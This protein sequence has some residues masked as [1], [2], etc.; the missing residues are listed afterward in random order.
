[1]ISVEFPS[2]KRK[3][4]TSRVPRSIGCYICGRQYMLHSF[5]IHEEQCRKLFIDRELLKPLKER[6]KIPDNPFNK[7]LIS[8]NKNSVEEMNDIAYTAYT[9]NLSSCKYCDRKFNQDKLKIH[10]KSCTAV[11]PA[12]RVDESVNRRT[13]MSDMKQMEYTLDRIEKD[14]I[15]FS[16]LAAYSTLVPAELQQCPHCNRSFNER[17]Y[18]KH[19]KIC[20]KVF[21]DK[22]KAFDSRKKRIEGTELASFYNDKRKRIGSSKIASKT[23][24]YFENNNKVE[25]SSK[26]RQQSQQFRQAMKA[27]RIVKIAQNRSKE[28]GIP[29]A[30]LLPQSL[31]NNEMDYN[32]YIT[33]PTCGRRFNEISGQRHITHCQSIRNKPSVLL[34]RSGH[35]ATTFRDELTRQKMR[36]NSY[37]IDMKKK[38]SDLKSLLKT[39]TKF[40]RNSFDRSFKQIMGNKTAKE[41]TAKEF[42][43]FSQTPPKTRIRR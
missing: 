24:G 33:C 1:M 35:V 34:A 2:E 29:L 23:T 42:I 18:E 40:D 41:T 11:N 7:T 32:D 4:A 36:R 8:D 19:K 22:R 30:S 10:N 28:S 14:N 13:S 3:K 39:T 31:P 15:N 26:W 16:K 6:R 25:N 37:D 5:N 17:S 38:D 9:A 27:A 12:R 21:V 20:K 43:L